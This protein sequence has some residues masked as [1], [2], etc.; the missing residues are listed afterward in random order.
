M[1]VVISTP[2]PPVAYYILFIEGQRSDID[3]PSIIGPFRSST[4]L[5]SALPS[6]AR[7][8]AVRFYIYTEITRRLHKILIPSSIVIA[9][10]F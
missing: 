10:V 8:S 3:Q 1:V 7:D 9:I 5:R 6:F 2:K 4:V